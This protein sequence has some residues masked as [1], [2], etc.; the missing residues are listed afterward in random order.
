VVSFKV[1]ADAT[2]CQA[3]SFDVMALPG[4]GITGPA[5]LAGKT[6]AVNL[7][8]N[9]QTLTLDSVLTS[10]GLKASSVH[11]VEVPF[12]DMV[13]ALKAHRVDAISAIEPYITASEEQD[14]A[15]SVMSQCTGPTSGFPLSGYFATSAWAAKYPNTAKA[16]QK[17]IDKAQALADSDPQA[18]RAVLPTYTAITAKTADVLNLNS[19]PTAVS[20][21]ALKQVAT[22][23]HSQGMLSKPLNVTSVMLP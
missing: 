13:A 17:A 5:S 14:G 12:P 11:Y 23:M 10:N 15:V 3:D 4:S 2:H 21:A 18:V 16:F 6:V 1:L 20:E 19:Y 22:L 8:G 7:T 9:V